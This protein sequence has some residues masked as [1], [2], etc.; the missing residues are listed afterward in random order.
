M[1]KQCTINSI[2]LIKSTKQIVDASNSRYEVPLDTSEG[3]VGASSDILFETSFTEND[4][5]S[6]TYTLKRKSTGENVLVFT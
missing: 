4:G 6:A 5:E 2:F 1:E 3:G